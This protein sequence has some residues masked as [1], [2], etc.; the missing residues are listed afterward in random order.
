MRG[1]FLI[2][3]AM[4]VTCHAQGQIDWEAPFPP[5]R[6]IDNVWFVGTEALG[7]YLITTAEGH[8]LINSDFESTVPIIKD[9]VERLGFRFEDIR[10]LLGS[11]AHGDHMQADALVKEMTGAEVM[12]MEQDVPLVRQMRPGGKEHPVDRVLHDGDTVTL[13]DTT[14]T[15]LLT[16]GHTPGC[17]TWTLNVTDNGQT[18]N[19]VIACSYGA[20]DNYVLVNNTDYPAIAED[21]PRTYE[22]VR[23][24]G[25][26]VFLGSH[27]FFFDLNRKYQELQGMKPTETNPYI[28]PQ[29]FLDHVDQVEANFLRMLSEQQR[30]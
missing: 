2:F 23:N 17:T 13:G 27:G 10:I 14:L 7:T 16:P 3:S 22:K 26:E 30:R 29:G 24:L 1:K 5:H 6:M 4:A 20:N 25:A 9:N 15:A 28:D 11:H 12:I 21:Y 8:I 19:A 18:Y